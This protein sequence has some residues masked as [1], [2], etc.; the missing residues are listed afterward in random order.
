MRSKMD[1]DEIGEGNEKAARQG[2]RRSGH[3]TL[4]STT[5]QRIQCVVDDSETVAPAL[6]AAAAVIILI[7]LCCTLFFGPKSMKNI[8]AVPTTAM[9]AAN[10]TGTRCPCLRL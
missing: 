3:L 9:I 2:L 6:S 5:R 1:I 8:A 4:A 10:A 7:P